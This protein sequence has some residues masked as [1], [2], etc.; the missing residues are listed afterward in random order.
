MKRDPSFAPLSR[1]H[2]QA[3][4]VAQKLRRA[5]DPDAAGADFLTFWREH[6][7]DHFRLE[8]EVVLPAWAA[9]AEPE[10]DLMARI[11]IEHARIRAAAE[12]LQE[13][14]MELADL[15]ALGDLLRD[16]VRFEER[17]LF[18]RIEA[19]LGEEGL[20]RIAPAIASAEAGNTLP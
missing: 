4:F 14:G 5:S 12:A 17:E 1:E 18:P 16:H 13:K 10:A 11:G 8:E 15:A 2:H 9:V 19:A 3:L 20:A 6:G 7:R